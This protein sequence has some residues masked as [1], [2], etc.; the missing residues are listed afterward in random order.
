MENYISEESDRYC[1]YRFVQ[2]YFHLLVVYCNT[3]RE[4]IH[5][6]PIYDFRAVVAVM[7]L[8]NDSMIFRATNCRPYD[9]FIYLFP[10]LDSCRN[11]TAGDFLPCIS[12]RLSCKII[13]RGM[14]NN[15]FTDNFLYCKTVA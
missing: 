5:P 10:L 1:A 7:K 15:S 13:G 11:N 2:R 3:S 14:D 8:Y 4:Q 6:F 12:R 9:S